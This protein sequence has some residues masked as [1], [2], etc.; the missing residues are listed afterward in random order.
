MCE[1]SEYEAEIDEF[2]NTAEKIKFFGK[3]LV[4]KTKSEEETEHNNFI[5]VILYAI[6]FDKQIKTNIRDR[7]DF[8]KAIDG[9]F[10]FYF[11]WFIINVQQLKSK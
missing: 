8:K 9:N 1:C 6:R 10:C 5:E 4:P 7:N 2:E 3:T 11:D